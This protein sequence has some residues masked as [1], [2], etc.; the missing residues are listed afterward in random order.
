LAVTGLAPLWCTFFLTDSSFFLQGFLPKGDDGIAVLKNRALKYDL[1]VHSAVVILVSVWI[2]IFHFNRKAVE[3]LTLGFFATEMKCLCSTAVLSL[4]NEYGPVVPVPRHLSGNMPNFFLL[5]T[6]RW[7][8][9]LS[10][11]QKLD[12]Y[13]VDKTSSNIIAL[14][15]AICV[16]CIRGNRKSTSAVLQDQQAEFYA[17]SSLLQL[18][19]YDDICLDRPVESRSGTIAKDGLKKMKERIEGKKMEKKVLEDKSWLTG[20][21]LKFHVNRS[22]FRKNTPDGSDRRPTG[23]FLSLL[24]VAR[25]LLSWRYYDKEGTRHRLDPNFMRTLDDELGVIT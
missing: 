22:A 14:V 5:M 15:F 20:L 18:P 8:D 17:S 4:F 19:F 12:L 21:D 6:N 24:E 9:G 3:D 7:F 10:W 11:D 1:Y 23:V 25:L 16:L 13:S 2:K